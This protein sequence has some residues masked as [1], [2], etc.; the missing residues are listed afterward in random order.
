MN[1]KELL[2]TGIDKYLLKPVFASAIIECLNECLD[3]ESARQE[4]TFVKATRGQFEGKKLLLVE[5]VDF[6]R[7]VIVALLR[8]TGLE[9]DEAEDGRE[10][11]KKVKAAPER[12]DLVFMDLQMPK[13]D[14]LEAT[15]RIR[16]LDSEYAKKLP[17][18]AL[19][20]NTFKEDVEKCFAAGMDGHL[21]KPLN[22]KDI[23]A[24]MKKY[25]G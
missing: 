25:L 18:V 4:K 5:D 17:I 3:V 15:R 11:V 16:A 13:M 2:A 14:G 9:I 12:Y 6:N 1:D 7:E 24:V 10:A 21:G 20:A 22:M 8:K 19:T 23:I